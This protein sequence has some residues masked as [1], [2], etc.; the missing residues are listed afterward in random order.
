MPNVS[1]A[2]T[3]DLPIIAYRKDEND[4]CGEYHPTQRTPEGKWARSRGWRV[5]GEVV[6]GSVTIVNVLRRYGYE[7]K[8]CNQIDGRGVLFD[9][10]CPIAAIHVGKP[11]DTLQAEEL[12]DIGNGALRLKNLWVKPF[13]DL[14]VKG[15]DVEIRPLPP[16]RR[17][18]RQGD[19]TQC[20]RKVVCA[21]PLN[22]T[23][24]GM[25]AGPGSRACAL[26]KCGWQ[27]V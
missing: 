19:I 21:D 1:I 27:F 12:V 13:D 26:K 20:F 18:L 7:A 22:I 15:H 5:G 24:I 2:P 11:D 16:D 10:G 8:A 14:F 3:A 25:E 6:F 4:F 23:R 9:H 17:D